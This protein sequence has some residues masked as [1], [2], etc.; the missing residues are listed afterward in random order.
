MNGPVTKDGLLVALKQ[1]LAA[2]VSADILDRF[3]ASISVEGG[4]VA[5]MSYGEIERSLS[6]ADFSRLL[7]QLHITGA[8]FQ[9]YKD[10]SCEGNIQ[11]RFCVDNPGNYCNPSYC[12]GN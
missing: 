2:K 5:H 7:G 11:A 8:T 3:L 6:A 4:Y 9:A 10:K 1:S 12:H